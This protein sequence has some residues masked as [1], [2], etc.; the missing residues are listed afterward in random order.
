MPEQLPDMRPVYSSH[1]RRIGWQDG[2]L[3]V[4]WDSGKVSAYDGVPEKLAGEIANARSVG[5]ALHSTVK[6]R[7]EHRY[8]GETS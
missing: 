3:Y 5:S 1:V 6:G 2:T 8:V 7:F 4:E